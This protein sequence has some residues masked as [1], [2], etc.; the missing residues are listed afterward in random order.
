MIF[1]LRLQILIPSPAFWFRPLSNYKQS[2]LFLSL[3]EQ[4]YKHW[5]EGPFGYS[6]LNWSFRDVFLIQR[7]LG[8]SGLNFS[9]WDEFV[10]WD[11]FGILGWIV[12]LHWTPQPRLFFDVDLQPRTKKCLDFGAI[13]LDTPHKNT[14][15]LSKS[16]IFAMQDKLWST[17]LTISGK[18]YI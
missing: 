7:Q 13:M 8:H 1:Q 14:V 5:A 4:N 6:E 11:E 10:I 15:F 18:T 17:W 9:F 2:R 16:T 12:P 3:C